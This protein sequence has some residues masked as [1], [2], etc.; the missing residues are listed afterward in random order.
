MLLGPFGFGITAFEF[1]HQN[2]GDLARVSAIEKL[3][4]EKTPPIHKVLQAALA[5]KDPAVRAASAKAL[6]G[7]RDEAT[8]MALYALFVDPKYPVRLTAAASY[9][10]TTGVAGPPPARAIRGLFR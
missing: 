2:G 6:V 4:Q 1:V 10:R 8:S 9:L 5:D 3:S 7:Y